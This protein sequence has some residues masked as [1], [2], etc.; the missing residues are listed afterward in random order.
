[1]QI[2]IMTATGRHERGAILIHVGDRRNGPDGVSPPL[3]LDYGV[4]WLGR[5]QAQNAADAG[6]LAGAVARL[7]DETGTTG[8]PDGPTKASC[9][10]CRAKAISVL[11]AVPGVTVEYRSTPSFAPEPSNGV[12]RPC[13]VYRDG[14]HGSTRLPT[15][16]A[17]LW[18]QTSRR[19]FARPL[20]PKSARRIHELSEAVD[21]CRSIRH[22]HL[23]EADIGTLLILRDRDG[24]GRSAS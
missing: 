20:R 5:R 19:T 7:F 24:P 14:T 22:E 12:L 10:G 11:G 21:D 8:D 9:D 13:G 15:Y 3:S 18:G 17:K 2:T 6:A 23:H 1:M 16:F 4:F